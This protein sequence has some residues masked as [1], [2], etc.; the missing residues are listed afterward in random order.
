[1][2]ATILACLSAGAFVGSFVTLA[3]I[4][5]TVEKPKQVQGCRAP[6]D[7]GEKLVVTL[8]EKDGGLHEQCSYYPVTTPKGSK[9]MKDWRSKL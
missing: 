8:Y 4:E 9:D 3:S 7:Q 2:N 6:V 1:M 5:H